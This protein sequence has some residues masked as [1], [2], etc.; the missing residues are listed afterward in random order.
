MVIFKRPNRGGKKTF[1]RSEQEKRC[2]YT[3]WYIGFP[4][5]YPQYRKKSW[6]QHYK[7]DK[8]IFLRP[9]PVP[10]LEEEKSI[11]FLQL[12]NT[13]KCFQK[14]LTRKNCQSDFDYLFHFR[15]TNCL[16]Y[17]GLSWNSPNLGGNQYV[18]YI[19]SGAVEI[20]AYIF[21]AFTLDKWGRRFILAGSLMVSSFV[22]LATIFVPSGN[23]KIRR[24]NNK[25]KNFQI[26]I[27]LK[28]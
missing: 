8:T 21:L 5:G 25:K 1:T 9:F 14:L 18:N 27:N 23:K 16:T 12:V 22:L 17:Y 10:E 19:I 3:R 15:F 4:S 2:Q 20:P 13:Q 7:R 28:V 24:N 26:K 6:K 11:N